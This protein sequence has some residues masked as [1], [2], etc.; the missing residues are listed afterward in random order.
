MVALTRAIIIHVHAALS[1][2][3]PGIEA[4]YRH[5][6]LVH[7]WSA[8]RSLSTHAD[9]LWFDFCFTNASRQLYTVEFFFLVFFPAKTD[10]YIQLYQMHDCA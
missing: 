5:I 6:Q 1:A 2:R 3:R 7:A 10:L 8:I 9:C 4:I